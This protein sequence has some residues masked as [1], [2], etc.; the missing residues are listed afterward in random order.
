MADGF[1]DVILPTNPI[2]L[3]SLSMSGVSYGT[4]VKRTWLLQI[5]LLILSFSVLGFGILIGY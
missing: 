3:I 5:A 4:W 1:T 2:L